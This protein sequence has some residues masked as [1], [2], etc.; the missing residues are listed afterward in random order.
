M[1]RSYTC[2]YFRKFFE[3]DC[4][5]FICAQEELATMRFIHTSDWHIGKTLNDF[6]L[7]DDQWETFLQIEH[8]AKQKN[9]EAI[10]IA[11][12]LYDR[13]VPSEASIDLLNGMLAQLNLKD[14][15]PLLA[16][17]GNH[18]SATRL[19]VGSKWF[20]ERQFYLNTDFDNAFSPVQIGD[21]QFFL[22]PFFGIQQAKNYFED[23]SIRTVNDAMVRIVSEMQEKF[24]PDCAHVLVAHFFAAGGKRTKDVETLVE[25]GG[26]NPVALD[27]LAPFDYVALGHL[28]NS[29]ALENNA[30]I[31]YSGAPMKFSVS[32]EK[33]QKGVWVVDV[34]PHQDLAMK[35]VS[36]KP[37]R[38]I[39]CVTGSFEDLTA[40]NDKTKELIPWSHNDFY[41]F[42]ITDTN[43][44]PHLMDALRKHYPYTLSVQRAHS[45]AL[46][47]ELKAHKRLAQNPS[48]L[49][50]DFFK[51]TMGKEMSAVQQ[52]AADETLDAARK[53]EA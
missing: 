19:G 23:E 37:V 47:S 27:M 53:K 28:H 46:E 8:I 9:A 5:E 32:E 17:S 21:A 43:H 3:I 49:L 14:G 15:F 18:D 36:L 10:V 40:Q 25:V 16:I 34:A 11:G 52:K 26:L 35:W 24:D 20:S 48:E 6:D 38:D 39:H 2:L 42:T 45:V 29:H 4:W 22:L 30:R 51:I 31:H 33:Q 13:S 50:S 7:H 41:A 12:D 1:I 44:I